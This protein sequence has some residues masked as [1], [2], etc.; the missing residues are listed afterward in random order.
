MTEETESDRLWRTSRGRRRRHPPAGNDSPPFQY[1][2]VT[3]LTMVLEQDPSAPS[4]ITHSGMAT[5]TRRLPR[6]DGRSLISAGSRAS[7]GKPP[8]EAVILTKGY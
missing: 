7:R 4:E 3:P 1:G 8:V 5:G 6:A 2:R